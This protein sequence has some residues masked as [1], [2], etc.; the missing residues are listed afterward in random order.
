MDSILSSY[1]VEICWYTRTFVMGLC[2]LRPCVIIVRL[3]TCRLFLTD[4]VLLRKEHQTHTQ[5]DC[6][7][8][9]PQTAQFR[10]E[11]ISTDLNF[12]K[13]CPRATWR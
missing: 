11:R 4:K 6:N 8:I 7:D 12:T 10:N 5:T 1:Q 2:S 3:C 13:Y 9:R